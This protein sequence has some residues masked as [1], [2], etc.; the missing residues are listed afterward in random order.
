MSYHSDNILGAYLT[1]RGCFGKICASL[2]AGR[3]KKPKAVF[4]SHDL[5]VL[6]G[7]VNVL[8]TRPRGHIPLGV[9]S[10]KTQT[11]SFPSN[12]ASGSGFVHFFLVFRVGMY[13]FRS[14]FPDFESLSHLGPRLRL[15]CRSLFE[16]TRWDIGKRSTDQ[17]VVG[18][19]GVLVLD[20]TANEC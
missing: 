11:T 3:V 19:Q 9:Y 5:A 13:S 10:S 12:L 20:V 18:C 14:F 4:T 1:C 16:D 15:D 8:V 7:P 17:K 6:S 2:T